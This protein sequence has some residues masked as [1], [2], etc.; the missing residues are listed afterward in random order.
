MLEVQHLFAVA[1]IGY[2]MADSQLH[3]QLLVSSIH[4]NKT[5]RLMKEMPACR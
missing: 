1:S 2:T 5:D 3:T 4:D